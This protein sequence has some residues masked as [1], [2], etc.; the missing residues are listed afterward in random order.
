[1][2]KW[3]KNDF[4]EYFYS[5]YQNNF[6]SRQYQNEKKK[7]I[8]KCIHNKS[9]GTLFAATGAGKT[10]IVNNV[11]HD[12]LSNNPEKSVL[13]VA[14]SW[15][16]LFQASRD[17]H[18]RFCT[19][20]EY[21][22]TRAGGNN[23]CLNFLLN[24]D[25]VE[26]DDQMPDLIYTTMKSL[27][28]SNRLDNIIPNIDVI[29]IDESHIGHNRGMAEELLAK[30][31]EYN[32]D[33]SIVGMT[34]TPRVGVFPIIGKPLSVP[35]L[36]KNNFLVRVEQPYGEPIFTDIDYESEIQPSNIEG[37][38]ENIVNFE[39]RND[40]IIDTFFE[41]SWGKTLIFAISPEHCE[42]LKEKILDKDS[43]RQVY[44]IHYEIKP[45][46]EVSQRII[47]F[48]KSRNG[49]LINVNMATTGFDCP[50]IKTIF[51]T[52]P[53][54]S[55][56]LYAQMIGRGL[57]KAKNKSHLNLVEFTDNYGKYQDLFL[58]SKRFFASASNDDYASSGGFSDHYKNADFKYSPE[59]NFK[60]YDLKI[61]NETFAIPINESQSFG[62]EFEITHEDPGV[63]ETCFVEDSGLWDKYAKIIV[64][65]VNTAYGGDV[66]YSCD[67]G[68][69]NPP[70][71]YAKEYAVVY[72]GSCGWEVVTPVLIGR[73]D[74]R[75]LE[76]VLKGLYRNL[77]KHGL[78]VNFTT[79]TH[80]HFGYDLPRQGKL[81]NF[82]NNIRNIEQYVSL[83]VSPSR[84]CLYSPEND[85]YFIKHSNKYCESWSF[86]YSDT[87]LLKIKTKAALVKKLEKL[88]F[89][90]KYMT[91][92]VSKLAYS[93]NPRTI[94]VRLHNGTLLASKIIPWISLWMLLLEKMK[95]DYGLR[96]KKILP[97]PDE[98]TFN[99]FEEV[100]RM[101]VGDEDDLIEILLN[102]VNE[103][104]E[105]W[106]NLE[107]ID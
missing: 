62:V 76:K 63:L 97:I 48:K 93:E 42:I 12:V 75:N 66:S 54:Q 55:E 44:S 58:D 31:E 10:Y 23:E 33:I 27:Y 40:L 80:V 86:H 26:D 34:A 87:E 100:I 92:N 79:G 74:L 99:D 59:S 78:Y 104:Y 52:R 29:F 25:D 16:L 39:E 106:S 53:T 24:F 35:F 20:E 6:E 19:D 41:R 77:K 88:D 36:Q 7:E 105:L 2:S 3:S 47:D 50:D 101:I 95:E 91:L 82:L 38:F 98:E 94:E 90:P 61:K 85:E 9:R 21:E 72:D 17:L 49:V 81:S 18:H 83:L 103:I 15:P 73:K 107:I 51:M 69:H 67:Y 71:D 37:S 13:F 60:P 70:L 46:S 14:P 56:V 8:L 89:H 30:V 68:D 11:I 65:E 102:R 28:S 1:M 45:S 57:R 64:D 4:R 22:I 84:V 96:F 43:T 32:A 5:E